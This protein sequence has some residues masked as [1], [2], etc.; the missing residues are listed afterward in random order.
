M[1]AFDFTGRM[2]PAGRR[3]ESPGLDI[4]FKFSSSGLVIGWWLKLW[5]GHPYPTQIW[6]PPRGVRT[7]RHIY[8][9]APSIQTCP[10]V[11]SPQSKLAP[12]TNSPHFLCMVS[13]VRAWFVLVVFYHR[14]N[15]YLAL[16]VMVLVQQTAWSINVMCTQSC[17][18]AIELY[19]CLIVEH[20]SM[21]LRPYSGWPGCIEV[22]FFPSVSLTVY[23]NGTGG[24]LSRTRHIIPETLQ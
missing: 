14:S 7:T 11:K 8:K 4:G 1:E 23:G 13:T 2:W 3:L 21:A 15:V 18:Y 24:F 12:N 22:L 16:Q 9:L 5:A 20:Y 19:W 6:V 10:I 17:Q